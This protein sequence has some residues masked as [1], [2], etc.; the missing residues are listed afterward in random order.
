MDLL[1]KTKNRNIYRKV[2]C[3]PA[4]EQFILHSVLTCVIQIG[5]RTESLKCSSKTVFSGPNITGPQS[6]NFMDKYLKKNH[7]NY[8]LIRMPCDIEFYI[9]VAPCD[10]FTIKYLTFPH[11]DCVLWPVLAKNVD[12]KQWRV[13]FLEDLH[14]CDNVS[15]EPHSLLVPLANQSGENRANFVL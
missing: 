4:S 7:K 8:I 6:Y 11:K 3:A 9:L 12:F 10:E 1:K 5:V 2:L 13:L 15:E 14:S